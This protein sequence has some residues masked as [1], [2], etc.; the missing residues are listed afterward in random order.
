MSSSSQALAAE[1]QYLDHSHI[2]KDIADIFI[3]DPMDQR[4]S[5][6][7]SSKPPRR[8]LIEG[9]PGIGKTV[10]AKEIAYRWADK[11]VLPDV[12]LLLLIYLRDPHLREIKEIKELLQLFTSPK[13]QLM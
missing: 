8:I 1:K 4:E 12:K 7:V 11:E 5:N 2:T 13:K 3:A 9:A 10:L 6:T